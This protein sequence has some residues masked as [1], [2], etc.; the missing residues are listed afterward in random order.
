M[1]KSPADVISTVPRPKVLERLKTCHRFYLS[2]IEP[3]FKGIHLDLKLLRHAIESCFLDM[4]RMKS[5]HGIDFADAHKR[6]AFL[7]LWIVKAHPIQLATDANI[8]EALIVVNELFA[9]HL[10]LG[11]LD[12]NVS[13][14]SREYLRNLI[15]ILHLRNPASE[16]LPH[17]CMFWNAP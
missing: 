5:F 13:N 12:V 17:Q 1:S 6:A 11:H 9:V 15:Y 8:T 4:A 7:M 14:I 3:N 16:L 10:G 2:F